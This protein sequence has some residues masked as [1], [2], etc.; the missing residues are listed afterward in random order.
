MAYNVSD[1]MARSGYGRPGGILDNPVKRPEFKFPALPAM[2]NI[3]ETALPSPV[4]PKP[5]ERRSF[6][7]M[8]TAPTSPGSWF[9]EGKG[10]AY[11]VMPDQYAY[12]TAYTSTPERG[13]RYR[14]PE[15]VGGGDIVGETLNPGDYMAPEVRARQELDERYGVGY[16]ERRLTDDQLG[17]YG[18]PGR[19]KA[20]EFR[21]SHGY[22]PMGW[23][24]E[25]MTNP[26][27]GPADAIYLE[28][29][30]FRGETEEWEAGAVKIDYP[31]EDE[32]KWYN[33][34]YDFP[35][36]YDNPQGPYQQAVNYL[37]QRGE[38]GTELLAAQKSTF[39]IQSGHRTDVEGY[40]TQ[41]DIYNTAVGGVAETYNTDVDLYSGRL[42]GIEQAEANYAEDRRIFGE[43]SKWNLLADVVSN[44][45]TARAGVI[46][47]DPRGYEIGGLQRLA[48][49]YGYSEQQARQ[50]NVGYD[51]SYSRPKYFD[52]SA[53]FRGYADQPSMQYETRPT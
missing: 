27:Y 16:F 17:R 42:S 33:P 20:A 6:G 47:E 35:T 25:F 1:I 5:L 7:A 31:R 51:E 40:N 14:G 34:S 26:S 18:A 46:G 8:P 29:P 48:D 2:Q 3:S 32:K 15:A 11:S 24:L 21:A 12:L 52:P 50:G 30:N 37:K 39:D 36:S 53:L 13:K 9:D 4:R 22:N 41:V 44:R 43:A 10:A 49:V 28:N 19:T 45:M 23:Q 38:Y